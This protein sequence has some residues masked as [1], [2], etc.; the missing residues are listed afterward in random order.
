MKQVRKLNIIYLLTTLTGSLLIA[1]CHGSAPEATAEVD[2]PLIEK[3]VLSPEVVPGGTIR[4]QRSQLVRHIGT[5]GVF[6]LSEKGQ[7]RFRMVKTGKSSGEWIIITSGLT[8]EEKILTGPFESMFDGS[9]VRL[10][11]ADEE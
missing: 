8:G 4:I 10:I 3:A 2:L 5:E 9:P 7:A 6:I 11:K 1:G